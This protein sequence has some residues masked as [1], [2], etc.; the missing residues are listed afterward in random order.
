MRRRLARLLLPGLLPFALLTAAPAH[1]ATLAG[2]FDGQAHLPCFGCGTSNGTFDG[3]FS[4]VLAN[5]TVAGVPM[6]AAFTYTEDGAT[7]P[8]SGNAAGAATIGASSY[9]FEWI[10]YGSD[11]LITFTGASTGNGRATFAV[12]TPVGLPCGGAVV[13]NV[14]GQLAGV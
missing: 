7:C 5:V 11:A 2:Q 12:T 13:A 4:G 1:A 3:T 14:H 8:V 9:Q 6:H 10:R